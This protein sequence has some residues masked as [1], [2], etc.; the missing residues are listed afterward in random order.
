MCRA[1]STIVPGMHPQPH[2]P[3]TWLIVLGLMLATLLAYEPVRH[4]DFVRYDDQ[5]YVFENAIVQRGLTWEGFLWA[6]TQPHAANWHPITWLSHML[7]SQLF[8]PGPAGPHLINVALHAANAA[9]LFLLLR[10]LTGFPW[11]SALVAALFALHPLRVESVAWI[12]E[13]KD[14]LCAF[15][16]LGSMLAYTIYVRQRPPQHWSKSKSYWL[17]FA[18][19]GLGLMSKPMLVTLPFALLLLDYWPLQRFISNRGRWNWASLLIEKTPFFLLSIG[20]SF[21]TIQVQQPDKMFYAELPLAARLSNAFVS[22]PR[23]LAKTFWPS[24]LA[25]IYPHPGQWS[26]G[27]TIA[28]VILVV[29]ISVLACFQLRPRPYLAVGWFWFC[30]LLIPVLGLVQ[31][32]MQSMADRYTYLP[33][34]GVFILVVWCASETQ[35]KL[36]W[37]SR[38]SVVIATSL[39]FVCASI[40]RA[41]LRV[42]QNSET[43]FNHALNVTRDNWVAHYNLAVVALKRHENRFRQPIEQQ[44]LDAAPTPGTLNSEDYLAK[45]IHHCESVIRLKPGLADPRALQAKALI[46]QGQLDAAQPLLEAA[47]RLDPRHFEA[48]QNYAEILLRR[49]Q[50]GRAVT[51]YQA[52]LQLNSDWPPVLNNLAWVLAT[53]PEPRLRNGPEAVRLAKRACELSGRTNLWFLQTL[54][55]AYAET[56]QFTNAVAAAG[57]ALQLARAAQQPQLMELTRRRIELYQSHQP[58]R[59]APAAG[60]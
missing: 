45:V 13:R 24:D 33:L 27:L 12:A 9:L 56:G 14:L 22:I 4:H 59:D 25:V 23:Y 44:F 21:I 30:G 5:E 3:R 8:G 34:I 55:A 49:K 6:F 54:A 32:G 28:A 11:R 53:H 50:V 57:E 58:Y 17:A 46:E 36:Q 37:S 40:T 2:P 7:D 35:L 26:T 18:L 15:W 60:P 29:V 10:S 39:L 48:R 52:A 43:L 1:A 20:M 19:F 47:I 31:V 16:G 41:Q 38:A 42:W 51:E